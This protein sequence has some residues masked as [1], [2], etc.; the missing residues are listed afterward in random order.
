M[1]FRRTSISLNAARTALRYAS[2]FDSMASCARRNPRERRP[3]STRVCARFAAVTKK[4]SGASS[5]ARRESLEMLPDAVNVMSGRKAARARRTSAC[6]ARKLASAC[7]RSGRRASNSAGRPGCTSGTRMCPRVSVAM[8]KPCT[9]RP[10]RSA[11]D[12]RA[13]NSSWTRFFTVLRCRST[14]MDC[15]RASMGV[16]VPAST[17]A[18]TMRAI[19]SAFSRFCSAAAMRSWLMSTRKYADAA[20]PRIFSAA[21]AARAVAAS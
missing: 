6:A 5:K 19:C 12:A 10:S 14:A 15:C 16:M 20:V 4:P 7:A 3:S 13:A 1:P 21:S 9:E 2:R 11:R 17:R 8:S 18:C